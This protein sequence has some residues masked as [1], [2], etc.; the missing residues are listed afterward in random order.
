MDEGAKK[1]GSSWLE[2]YFERF[3]V[4]FTIKFGIS[5]LNVG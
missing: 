1:R 2:L 4:I 5:E 3:H